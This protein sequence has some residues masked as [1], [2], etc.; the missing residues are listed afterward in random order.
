[1]NQNELDKILENAEQQIRKLRQNLK[2]NQD[3]GT[4]IQTI[5][6]LL[7]ELASY[8]TE[9]LGVDSALEDKRRIYSDIVKF[10]RKQGTT[11]G[12]DHLYLSAA[13][14]LCGEDDSRLT[15]NTDRSQAAAGVVKWAREIILGIQVSYEKKT[16]NLYIFK[17]E[18]F[19][20]NSIDSS[21]IKNTYEIES[22]WDNL[23]P[24]V[25]EEFIRLKRNIIDY[26]W[27]PVEI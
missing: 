20:K 10:L 22:N 7:A 23:P 13:Y 5:I 12:V 16:E 17:T 26:I 8:L 4:L 24:K 25:R 2:N 11:K 15:N 14:I 9:Y 19:S 18:I 27:Y 1:M 21:T 3:S 6:V